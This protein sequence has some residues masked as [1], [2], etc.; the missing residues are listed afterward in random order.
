MRWLQ[1]VLT[2]NRFHMCMHRRCLLGWG[3]GKE[4]FYI[5]YHSKTVTSRSTQQDAAFFSGLCAIVITEAMQLQHSHS[6]SP[7]HVLTS[8]TGS[9][10]RHLCQEYTRFELVGRIYDSLGSQSQSC[11]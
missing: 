5:K 7:R 6:T 2:L 10:M 4:H 8:R 9:G 11:S 1:Q 3:S